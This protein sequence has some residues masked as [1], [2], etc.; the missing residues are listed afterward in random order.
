LDGSRPN[1]TKFFGSEPIQWQKAIG[2][3]NGELSV[4]ERET[5]RD[6]DKSPKH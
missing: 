1:G 5:S 3:Q 4:L 2:K 6:F